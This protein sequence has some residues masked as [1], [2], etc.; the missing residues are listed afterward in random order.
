MFPSLRSRLRPREGA[1]APAPPPGPSHGAFS[2]SFWEADEIFPSRSAAPLLPAPLCFP[3][4]GGDPGQALSSPLIPLGTAIPALPTARLRPELPVPLRALAVP[5]NRGTGEEGKRPTTAA[6][7]SPGVHLQP[8]FQLPGLRGIGAGED[9]AALHVDHFDREVA[10]LARLVQRL[11]DQRQA[12]GQY[13]GFFC[14]KTELAFTLTST[15]STK[16]TPGPP[17]G[18]TK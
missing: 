10:H 9:L 11:R 12:A 16:P 14:L 4:F 15:A 17:Q 5:W 13:F 6:R 8:S 18:R 2:T 7:D 3:R 1:G